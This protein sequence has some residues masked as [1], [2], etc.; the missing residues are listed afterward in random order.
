M[1]LLMILL[2]FDLVVI[3]RDFS[4]IRCCVRFLMFCLQPLPSGMELLVQFIQDN[5][6]RLKDLFFQF[7]KDHS[8][9]ITREEFKAGLKE[10]GIQMSEV[11]TI[12]ILKILLN[13]K[14]TI[15]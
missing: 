12:I 2:Y 9:D 14:T 4:F 10:T 15:K 7:D 8:G 6:M 5:R 3:L 11:I 13:V 1:K